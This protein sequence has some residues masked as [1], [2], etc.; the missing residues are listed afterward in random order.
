MNTRQI[1][2]E[3]LE[4]CNFGYADRSLIW[5]MKLIIYIGDKSEKHILLNKQVPINRF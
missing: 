1:R 5:V 3:D 4:K 2:I